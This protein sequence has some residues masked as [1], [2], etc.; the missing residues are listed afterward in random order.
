MA[1][2]LS[3]TQRLQSLLERIK[4]QQRQ[5]KTVQARFVQH[6]RSA[7]LVAPEESN[8]V[9]SYAA[10]DR[11]RW[12]YLS[13][14][15]ISVVIGP[16]EMTTWYH[17]LKRAE[18]LK[19]G[20]YS[21]QVFKFLGASNNMEALL[22]YF[23]VTLELSKKKGEPYR[24]EL[25]PRYERMKKRLKSMTIWVDADRFFPTR[26]RYDEVDGDATEY[27]FK[28][29]QLNAPIPPDRFALQLPPGVET[30]VV[31]LGREP[32]SGSRP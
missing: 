13:P 32:K 20:H 16:G 6:R 15:P 26:L 27:E 2:G 1:P 11:V 22:Q 17:D 23:T 29:L 25:L 14:T 4:T 24:L 19:I 5:I 10:P 18:T 30:K 3:G 9:F 8:G 31:D 7:M 28:D 21:N 12:E